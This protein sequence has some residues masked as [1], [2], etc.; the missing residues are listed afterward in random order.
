MPL[1]ALLPVTGA[2]EAVSGLPRSL[3]CAPC[4]CAA[5]A[6]H[7]SQE[8]EKRRIALSPASHYRGWQRLGSNVTQ[9]RRDWHEGID[10]YKA[11]VPYAWLPPAWLVVRGHGGGWSLVQ[12]L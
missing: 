3:G 11:R 6:P 9:G 4:R 5:A 2:G 12:Q 8:E 1:A 10:L 7:G